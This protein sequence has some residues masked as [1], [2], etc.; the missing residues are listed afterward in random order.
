MTQAELRKRLRAARIFNDY[1][2]LLRF[3]ETCKAVGFAYHIPMPRS[4]E[5]CKSLVFSPT[6]KTDPGA[7]WTDHG[8]KVFIGMLAESM[9]K[10]EAWASETYGV[11]EWSTSPFDRTTKIPTAALV[12]AREAMK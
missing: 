11:T 8:C 3:A 7:H 9:P 2:L 10:A 5:P 4:A 12:A 6:H 1:E